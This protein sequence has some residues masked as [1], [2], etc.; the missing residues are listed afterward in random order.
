MHRDPPSAPLVLVLP[1]AR[2]AELETLSRARY[3]RE[4]CGLLL[5]RRSSAG[6]EVVE[7]R[8]ARNLAARSDRFELDPTDHFAAEEAARALELE[9]VGLWHSHPDHPPV[10]SAADRAHREAAWSS[11]IVS[12]R[13]DGATELRAW[14]WEGTSFAAEPLSDIGSELVSEGQQLPTL[15]GLLRGRPPSSATIGCR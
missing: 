2:R 10:P 15:E 9:V 6:T 12:V 1:A 3:P 7:V 4:A 13:A 14:R 11:V 8:E 5:G